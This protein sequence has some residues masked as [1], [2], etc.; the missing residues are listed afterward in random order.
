M[1]AKEAEEFDEKLRVA[2]SV[3]ESLPP[4][5]EMA[6]RLHVQYG[7]TYKTIAEIMGRTRNAIDHL[8][9]EAKENIQAEKAYGQ[10]V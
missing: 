6:F 3:L 4:D 10:A 1:K 7:L 5:Q 9:R 8:L 2:E